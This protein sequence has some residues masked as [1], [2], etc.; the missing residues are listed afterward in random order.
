MIAKSCSQSGKRLKLKNTIKI[1]AGKK[2]IQTIKQ[3]GFSQEKVRMMLGASGG[4]KWLI[5]SELDKYLCGEFFKERKEVLHL[6]GSSIG[7]WRFA[8]YARKNPSEALETLK[9]NYIHFGSDYEGKP[10]IVVNM[11]LLSKISWEFIDSILNN[12]KNGI[13]EILDNP[14]FKLNFIGTSCKGLLKS[15]RKFPLLFGL[16]CVASANLVSRKALR[17]FSNRALFYSETNS[18]FY[19]INDFPTEKIN[20]KKDNLRKA[21][22]ASG[23]IP[24]L[25]HGVDN[26]PGTNPHNVYRDG[27]IIDYHF[28][29]NLEL[30]D[31]LVLYP[32]FYDFALPGW[33]DKIL[34]TRKCSIKNYEN[35]VMISPAPD[36]IEKLPFKKLSERKDFDKIETGERIKY[37]NKVVDMGK[38]IA[39]GF[40]K[41]I[42]N[43]DILSR[44]ESF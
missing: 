35:V 42:E 30:N 36:L 43:E 37:W 34:K 16:T 31:G 10:D 17:F 40:E 22:M 24:L 5:L 33:F 13:E 23:S 21:L 32:H 28:D 6:L 39:D 38:Y 12:D 3:N 9:K 29:L 11:D 2:A 1:Q 4:P 26:I 27:G 20:L 19:N 41:M 15:D 8:C 7:S 18:P 44:V 25:T 14:I